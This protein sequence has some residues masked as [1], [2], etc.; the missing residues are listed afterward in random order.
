MYSVNSQLPIAH[1]L[2][3][4]PAEISNS[5]LMSLR[6]MHLASAV[7]ASG[8]YSILLTLLRCND[9]ADDVMMQSLCQK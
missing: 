1:A 3:V 2:N 5:Y 8:T 7:Q 9:V 4:L 6:F